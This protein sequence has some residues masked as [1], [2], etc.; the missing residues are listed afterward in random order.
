MAVAEL[1]YPVLVEEKA[2]GYF[3]KLLNMRTVLVTGSAMTVRPEDDDKVIILDRAAGITAT[4]P[5]ASGS[6]RRFKFLVKTTASGGNYVVKVANASDTMIGVIESATTTGATT[7]GFAEAAGGTDDTITMN[8]T[9]TGGVA[10]SY[11]EVLD[12]LPNLWL[13]SGNLVASGV[14]ATSLSATV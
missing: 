4:L 13:I 2:R 6:G 11:I 8:G 1:T 7:N 10:G 9:T 12:V 3:D 5:A 14:L